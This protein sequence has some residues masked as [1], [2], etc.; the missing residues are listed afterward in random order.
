MRKGGHTSAMSATPTAVHNGSATGDHGG[1]RLRAALARRS[2]GLGAAAL[3]SLAGTAAA[4]GSLSVGSILSGDETPEPP[5]YR[6][7]DETVVALGSDPRVGRWRVVT[8]RSP[9]LVD[10]GEVIQPAG[11]PCLK[12]ALFG[13]SSEVLLATRS[14]CGQRGTG[15]LAGASLPVR[16][17]AGRVFTLLFGEA[18]EQ[19]AGVRLGDSNGKNQGATI[20]D[21]PPSGD[22]DFWVHVTA[23][24]RPAEQT[25]MEWIDP[26]GTPQGERVDLSRE[27]RQPLDPVLGGGD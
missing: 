6:Q 15:G 13:A 16:D 5:D 7:T 1:G 27:V 8:Y 26:D 3:L 17:S 4:A 9:E 14:Y 25:W 20:Y 12:L 23:R 22:G 11:L 21:G 10:R 2:A 24:G 19:A 18:P